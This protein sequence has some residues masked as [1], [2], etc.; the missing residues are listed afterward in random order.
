ML[1]RNGGFASFINVAIA[2]MD[3]PAHFFIV[4]NQP[5]TTQSMLRHKHLHTGKLRA[6]RIGREFSENESCSYLVLPIPLMELVEERGNLLTV[7]VC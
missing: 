1:S 3:L 4:I 6:K 5:I 7:R 2:V